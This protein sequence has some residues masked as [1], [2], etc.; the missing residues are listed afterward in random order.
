MKI[1]QGFVVAVGIVLVV[2]VALNFGFVR[3]NMEYW[4]QICCG[5][6]YGEQSKEE[7]NT[8]NMLYISSLGVEAPLVYME[9]EGGK[10]SEADFQTALE[11]GVVH[12]PGT[13]EV[14][15]LG[16]AYFFGH[17][18]DFPTKPGEYKSVF[19]LLPKIAMGEQI[20]LTD[21]RGKR[22]VYQ[23]FETH[24]VA[25]TDTHWLEQGDR[26]ERLLT[27]QTSYPVGTALKRFL[28]RARL[29]E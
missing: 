3:A 7:T 21:E 24:V 8:P 22:F 6:G 23:A 4:W 26:K 27:L 10:P 18:S 28:V 9:D 17:S 2:F 5:G 15:E 13:A 12:Y 29:V 14:G 1:L 20:V 19:A 16:N 25:P 11:N